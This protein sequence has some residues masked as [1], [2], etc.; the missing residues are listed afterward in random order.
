MNSYAKIKEA[1]SSYTSTEK[2]IA[3]YILENAADVLKCSAQSLGEKTGTSAAAII[4]FSKKLGYNG[5]SELKMSLA[6]SKRAPEEKIDFIISDVMMS[7]MDGIKFCKLVK[8]NIH[9]CHIPLILLTAKSTVGEQLT[10]LNTGADDYISKPF[11]FSV[12]RAKVQNILKGRQRAI[13]NYAANIEANPAQI[14][15]NGIDEELLNKAIG[16][17]EKNLENPN[18]SAE[19]FSREM[20]MSRS[21]LHLKLKALTGES[22]VEFI[23]RIR[24]GHA[25]RLLKE[26]KY[27]VS[28]I[29]TMVGFTPSYFTTSFK[30]YMGCLPS[31]YVKNSKI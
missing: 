2:V 4:R 18:F 26:G 16:I 8:Q 5:F 19:E 22:A 25:C 11:V 10:G 24:F 12:L 1:Q 7:V 28:E 20:G 14:A 9:F 31:E 13:R 21:N 3:K 29:S 15:S 27:N 23:R 30:K 17:I 6:Q